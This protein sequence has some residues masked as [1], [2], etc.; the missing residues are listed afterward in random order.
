M[1]R[2]LSL[3]GS[4]IAYL[5]TSK[6][7]SIDYLNQGYGREWGSGLAQRLPITGGFWNCTFST[8]S[9]ERTSYVSSLVRN[10]RP[11]AAIPHQ[12]YR[13]HV[14]TRVMM[15]LFRAAYCTTHARFRRIVDTAGRTVFQKLGRFPCT[16]P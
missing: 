8:D 15:R 5:S 13:F 10:A 6:K 12:A 2:K 7:L 11:Q 14:F 1:L 16:T 3:L 4:I 9:T